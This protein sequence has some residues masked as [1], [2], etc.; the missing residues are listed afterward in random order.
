MSLKGIAQETLAVIEAGRY[1]TPDGSV[2]EFGEAQRAAEAGTRLWTP[3]GLDELL[4]TTPQR[5]AGRTQT[6]IEVTKEST[7]AAA[8]RLAT[9]PSAKAVGALNFAS[10]R[11][12]GGGFIRGAKAQEED[13][14]RC[15]GL[16]PTLLRCPEYYTYNRDRKTLLYSD[17]M[18]YS[19]RV[20][21]FRIKS[22]SFC[23]RL[24]F[25]SVITAPAPN[26]GQVRKHAETDEATIES[27]FRRRVGKVL[28]LAESEGLTHLVLGAWGCGVF[29]ND[30]IMV[31]DAFAAWLDHPRFKNVFA[32]ITFAIYAKKATDPNLVAFQ[33]RSTQTTV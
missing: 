6:H 25:A 7:Q 17:H 3:E 26:A 24:Y 20:P 1:T 4:D 13:V 21:F 32:H 31:A 2:H 18:I 15:S 10:A 23:D 19:P 11:N 28:A 8:Y 16:Y 5:E 22:R 29:A 14:A 27:V 33:Q 9:Q 30:P 12:P